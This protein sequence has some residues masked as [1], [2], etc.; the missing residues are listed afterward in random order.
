MAM[1]QADAKTRAALVPANLTQRTGLVLGD[2]LSSAPLSRR[3]EAAPISVAGN[4]HVRA[5]RA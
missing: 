4:V 3:T 1:P 2:F 5:E